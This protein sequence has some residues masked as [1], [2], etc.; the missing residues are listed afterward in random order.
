VFDDGEIV[1]G[2]GRIAALAAVAPRRP[3]AASA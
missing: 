2:G 3:L 1:L